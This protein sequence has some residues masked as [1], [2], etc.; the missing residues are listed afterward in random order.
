MKTSRIQPDSA[1]SAAARTAAR[2]PS[3]QRIPARIRDRFFPALAYSGYAALWRANTGSMWAFSMQSVAQGWL[4]VSLTESPMMLGILG[5]FLSAPMVLLSPIGGILADRL[6]RARVIQAAQLMVLVGALTIGTLVALNWI[7]IWH[8]IIFSIMNGTSFAA[9]VPSRHAMV[10]DLVPRKV[11]PNA[12]ALNNTTHSTANFVGPALAGFLVAAF[13]IASAY[14]VQ[15]GAYVWSIVNVNLIGSTRTPPRGTASVLQ[16]M[17]AGFGYVLRQKSIRSLLLLGLAPSLLGWPVLTLTPA[18]VK[19]DLKGGPEDLGLLLGILG[20]GSLVGAMA[21][22]LLTGVR[23]KGRMVIS[24][25]LIQGA[26]ILILAMSRSFIQAGLALWFIGFGQAVYFAFNHSIIQ[27][28]VPSEIR[29]RV[30]SVWMIGW[31]LMPIGLLPISAVAERLGTTVAFAWAG[32][33]T[34]LFVLSV[35]VLSRDLWNLRPDDAA[36]DASASEPA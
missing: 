26:M 19:L 9:S 2:P 33:L 6:D 5:V 4:V 30:I 18:F 36:D 32:S 35:A 28:L 12:V 16:T 8:L 21:S 27:L 11:V 10:A 34:L 31:G 13:G 20:A 1:I 29:G 15:V 3:W 14:F 23:A 17:R 25:L 7:Q 22:I 24:A